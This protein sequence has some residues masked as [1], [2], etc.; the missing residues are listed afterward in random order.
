[1][2]DKL[3]ECPAEEAPRGRAELR[4]IYGGEIRV[5]PAANGDYLEARVPNADRLYELAVGNGS[6][7][8]NAEAAGGPTASVI[9][10]V[11]GGCNRTRLHVCPS[12][13]RRGRPANSGEGPIG[14]G[15]AT[16]KILE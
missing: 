9:I 11:A 7:F 1:M 6:N 4:R 8:R 16:L 14:D 3:A 2:I 5:R 12:A 10:G 13:P 15:Q